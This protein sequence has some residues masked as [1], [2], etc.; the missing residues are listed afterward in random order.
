MSSVSASANGW[1]LAPHRSRCPSTPADI[2]ELHLPLSYPAGEATR[3]E[4]SIRVVPAHI[5][6]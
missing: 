5:F 3:V 6:G 4:H 2:S 1:K